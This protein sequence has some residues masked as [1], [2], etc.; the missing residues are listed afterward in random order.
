M[1]TLSGA[2]LSG[3]TLSGAALSDLAR[4]AF[5]GSAVACGEMT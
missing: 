4:G 5:T 3:A 1:E 2:T